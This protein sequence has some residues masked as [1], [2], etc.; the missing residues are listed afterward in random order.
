MAKIF[1]VEKLSLNGDNIRIKSSDTNKFEIT[2]S[3]D[4]VLMSKST[5]ESDIASLSTLESQDVSTVNSSIASLST[6]ESEDVSTVNSSIASL[7]TLESEDVSTVNSSIASLSTL[8]SEDIST[9]NSSIGSVV[10]L[11]GDNDVVAI[12]TGLA[13]GSSSVAVD[14]GRQFTSEP[15]VTVTMVA[16][17][18]D[19]IIGC[20]LSDMSTGSCTVQFAD[21]IPNNNY[22]LKVLASI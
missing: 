16:G 4:S 15:A 10:E 20:Q 18:G 17:T 2:D 14:F 8:E 21:D 12:E 5:I 6:L 11:I 3:N 7:S 19:P 13:S 9:V 1:S 22:K